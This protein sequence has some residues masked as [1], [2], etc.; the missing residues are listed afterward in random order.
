M[1]L[2][3]FSL[4]E[5]VGN[6]R[7]RSATRNRLGQK[8]LKTDGPTGEKTHHRPIYKA[9]VEGGRYPLGKPYKASSEINNEEQAEKCTQETV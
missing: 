7:R 4:L 6:V 5:N 9:G 1:W 3:R 8:C 2:R